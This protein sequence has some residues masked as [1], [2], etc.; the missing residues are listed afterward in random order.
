VQT[1]TLCLFPSFIFSYFQL[2][3]FFVRSDLSICKV[4]KKN[5]HKLGFCRF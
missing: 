2:T 1:A 5:V 4:I 3:L